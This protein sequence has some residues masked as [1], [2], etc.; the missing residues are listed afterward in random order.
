MRQAQAST[1]YIFVVAAAFVFVVIAV[2][3]VMRSRFT[4]GN[5]VSSSMDSSIA[6]QISLLGNA[7]S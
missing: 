6:S 5:N 2:L 4:A 3:A 1:E 7:S